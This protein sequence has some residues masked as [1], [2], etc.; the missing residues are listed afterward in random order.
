MFLFVRVPLGSDRNES[1]RMFFNGCSIR[2]FEKRL[3]PPRAG[4]FYLFRWL[5]FH[6]LFKDVDINVSFVLQHLIDFFHSIFRFSNLGVGLLNSDI[7][8]CRIGLKNY[9][10]FAGK[11]DYFNRRSNLA[12][13]DRW[14]V[15]NIS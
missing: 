2:L 5:L 1:I 7:L 15:F 8:V 11:L 10:L 6:Y 4:W 9:S 3:L 14:E 13:L 12:P